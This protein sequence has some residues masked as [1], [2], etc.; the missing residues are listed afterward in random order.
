M[1]KDDLNQLKEG[2]TI[3]VKCRNGAMDG[4][5]VRAIFRGL[6]YPTWSKTKMYYHF[7]N[8]DYGTGSIFTETEDGLLGDDFIK[9]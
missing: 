3:R 6:K 5:S 9:W 2:D 7:E 1:T 8:V 4:R